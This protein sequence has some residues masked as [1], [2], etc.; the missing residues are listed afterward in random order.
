M[1]DDQVYN[2]IENEHRSFDEWPFDQNFYLIL[3]VTID[4]A[5]GGREGIDDSV[6]PQ[7][8][9]VSYVRVYQLK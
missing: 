3:I 2:H 8:M 7:Q 6:F 4:G 5:L 9:V 1:Q